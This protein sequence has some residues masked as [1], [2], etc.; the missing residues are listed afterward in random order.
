M[1]KFTNVRCL[2]SDSLVLL[3]LYWWQTYD[4]FADCILLLFFPFYSASFGYNRLDNI[5]CLSKLCACFFLY[6]R[7]RWIHPF[8]FQLLILLIKYA[9]I[10]LNC[11]RIF[12]NWFSRCLNHDDYY[13]HCFEENGSDDFSYRKYETFLRVS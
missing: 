10:K 9:Q 13:D 5:Q 6:Q 4:L 2:M 12:F 8:D 3:V 11:L 1:T 7:F